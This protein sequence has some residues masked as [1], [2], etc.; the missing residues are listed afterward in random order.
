MGEIGG[1]GIQAGE[2]LEV[3][4]SSGSWPAMAGEAVFGHERPD[5]LRE[6]LVEGSMRGSER[7]QADYSYE[8]RTDA[9][10]HQWVLFHGWASLGR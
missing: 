2:G 3:K 5:G 7:A 6:A 8:K 4:L 10:R 9:E 1:N